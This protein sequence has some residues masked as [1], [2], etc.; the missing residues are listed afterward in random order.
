[1]AAER[2]AQ[3]NLV[4]TLVD[5]AGH[6]CAI[7][8]MEPPLGCRTTPPV[9]LKSWDPVG[10][11]TPEVEISHVINAPPLTATAMSPAPTIVHLD[12]QR[13]ISESMAARLTAAVIQHVLFLKNQIP[14]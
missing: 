7:L 11:T 6:R 3:I 2:E 1:M 9:A 10:S 14:L 5:C 13:S 8:Q 4:V 12:E